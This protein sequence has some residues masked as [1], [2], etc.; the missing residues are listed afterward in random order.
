MQN[1]E[2]S[3]EVLA[4]IPIDE[5][6]GHAA[7]IPVLVGN[8]PDLDAIEEKLTAL[9]ESPFRC[10][11]H[12]LKKRLGRKRM[13]KV[14]IV[15]TPTAVQINLPPNQIDSDTR[16]IV[17]T[18]SKSESLCRF[19]HARGYPEVIEFPLEEA[20]L[21]QI[22]QGNGDTEPIV[23]S[24][25]PTP[26]PLSQPIQIRTRP[27]AR[28]R[29]CTLIDISQGGCQITD[30][31]QIPVGRRVKIWLDPE[32]SHGLQN[33]LW[34]RV[35]RAR[36]NPRGEHWKTIIDFTSPDGVSRRSS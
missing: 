26:P 19:L 15:D 36:F 33:G 17:I 20:S 22:L 16:R 2:K 8:D 10:E 9:G 11:G 1:T 14:L 24:C 12:L 32:G 3:A 30:R 7:V 35:L 28:S 31:K 18:R 29:V 6:E 27:W 34:G 21:E 23:E 5:G 13:A 4:N 25:P